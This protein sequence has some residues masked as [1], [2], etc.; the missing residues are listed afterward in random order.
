MD[1]RKLQRYK[2]DKLNPILAPL[3][4]ALVVEMP[5]DIPA[6]VVAFLGRSKFPG[7]VPTPDT[8]EKRRFVAENLNPLLVP[9]LSRIIAQQPDDVAGFLAQA[10]VAESD[11]LEAKQLQAAEGK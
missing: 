3:M 4:A 11:A 6:F 2:R 10:F 8:P 9:V 5:S 1:P 7:V